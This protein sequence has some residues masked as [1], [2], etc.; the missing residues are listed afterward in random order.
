MELTL[1]PYQTRTVEH[2]RD[3]ERAGRCRIC[4]QGP[5]GSGKSVKL[6]ALLLDDTPQ[7]VLTHRK[8][9]L[10]QLAGVL[11]RFG[12][13]FGYRASGYAENKSAGIQLG[14]IQSEWGR[15]F[16][17]CK[18]REWLL[19]AAARVHLDEIHANTGRVAQRMLQT[20]YDRGA[21]IIGYTASPI[22][23][24]H[25]V[26]ELHV[27]ATVP[28]LIGDGYL[29]PPV[30][31]TPDGPSAEKFEMLTPQSNGEYSAKEIEKVWQPKLVL[32]RVI[33]NYFRLNPLRKPAMLFAP[34]VPHSLWFAQQL[35]ASGIPSAHI[36]G[37]QIWSPVQLVTPKGQ[38]IPGDN[39]FYDSTQVARDAL[40]FLSRVGEI[41]VLCNRYLLREGLDAPWIEHV[42]LA[43]LF[44]SRASFVQACGRGLRPCHETGKTRCVFQDHGANFWRFPALDSDEP[45]EMGK[46]HRVLNK[47]YEE[48]RRA[49][50]DMKAPEPIVCSQC[51]CLRMS[52][53]ICPE[54]KF[55]HVTYARRVVEIDGKLGLSVGPMYA[56][57]PDKKPLTDEAMWK[58]HFW[59]ARLHSNR[60][61]N[62]VHAW[63]RKQT[64]R[65]DFPRNLPLMPRSEQDWSKPVASVPFGNLIPGDRK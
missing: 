41:R 59:G 21:S 25:L 10:D 49:G 33:E 27:T 26:D 14:M 3:R 12:V 11:T 35:T 19:P 29:V 15:S 44:G 13:K 23:I 61:F 43:T 30:I 1:R 6:A 62:H 4:I 31:Y 39:G 40:F 55:R 46:P 18:T 50:N 63:V 42:I 36:D 32:G 24:A 64:N 56:K 2:V 45:W 7:Y 58:R 17:G 5:T 51:Q 60:T 28:E 9:L 52:G 20:F 47:E 57:R 8:F 53:P 37:K 65:N 16:K 22:D 34:G 48:R 38:E 54:C